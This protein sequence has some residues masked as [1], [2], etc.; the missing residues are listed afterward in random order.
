MVPGRHC[1][2]PALLLA[3]L[4]MGAGLP[5]GALNVLPGGDV[6][7][8]AKVALNPGVS[9]VTYSGNK[10]VCEDVCVGFPGRRLRTAP[11]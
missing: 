8:G 1:A 6:P 3:Q 10:Q 5:A 2:P 11:T 7:L 9:Y 4:F